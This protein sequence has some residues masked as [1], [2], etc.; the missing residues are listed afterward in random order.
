MFKSNLNSPK[1][2]KF[3]KGRAYK[4]LVG[5]C[6]VAVTVAI[7]YLIVWAAPDFIS[8]TF[9]DETKIAS[10]ENLVV[11]GGQVKLAE[12]WTLDET[13]CNA[14]SG[15]Y[16]YTTNSRSACWSKTLADTVSWNK[17]VGNDV[18]NPGV[19]TCAVTPTGLQDRM[20]AV[21]AGEWYKIVSN[22][23]GTDITSGHNG[24]AGYS[25]ISALAIADCLDGTRDLCTGDG[26]LGADVAAVNVS[27]ATWA[28]A[29][30]D[31]SALPYCVGGDCSTQVNSDF[32]DACTQSSSNDLPLS[33]S[34]GLF[35]YNR[36]VCAD[37][38]SN[39]TWP[40]AAASA[41]MARL[42]GKDG[43]SCSTV[44]DY[45]TSFALT[46]FSFRVVVRP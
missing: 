34:D 46:S 41:T 45:E 40:A 37:G 8:D 16:W 25:V 2:N 36:R 3:A 44:D 26:C 39:Y 31:K 22:V 19:Y 38:D 7:G 43:D 18:D 30:S 42:L 20:E 10:K 4:I 14:L 12:I 9:D 29:T 15:W 17:G 5:I 27:L 23:A 11:T 28:S 1:Q 35:Y 6:S 32:Y 33:C 13:N 21:A 24:S